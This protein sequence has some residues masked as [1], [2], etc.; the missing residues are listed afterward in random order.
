MIADATIGI[1]TAVVRLE[2]LP[3]FVKRQVDIAKQAYT[4]ATGQ[5]SFCPEVV[6]AA[7][8]ELWHKS[9]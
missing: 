8:E 6:A 1:L 3:E 5:E 2:T 4:Q 9:S 7:R